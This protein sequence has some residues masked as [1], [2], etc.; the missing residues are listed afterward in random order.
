MTVSVVVNA[1]EHEVVVGRR[2][3]TEAE[4]GH[5]VEEAEEIVPAHSG[6]T[7]EVARGQTLLIDEVIPESDEHGEEE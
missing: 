1:G 7:F 4:V 6:K 3:V 2:T 5:H